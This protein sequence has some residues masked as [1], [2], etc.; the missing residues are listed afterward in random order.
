VATSGA[1]GL[2]VVESGTAPV[3]TVSVS[4]ATAAAAMC[5]ADRTP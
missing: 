3:P 4:N 5:P 1:N 2:E